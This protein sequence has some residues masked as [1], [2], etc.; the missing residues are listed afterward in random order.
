MDVTCCNPVSKDVFSDYFDTLMQLS[1]HMDIAP[2]QVE[3]NKFLKVALHKLST[4]IDSE[5]PIQRNIVGHNTKLVTQNICGFLNHIEVQLG[6]PQKLLIPA[7]ERTYQVDTDYEL[8]VLCYV[9]G[10]L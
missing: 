3:H 4:F 7:L 2:F 6:I 9:V 5:H 8:S 10:G 1:E